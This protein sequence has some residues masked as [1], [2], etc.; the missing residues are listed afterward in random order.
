MP[1]LPAAFPVGEEGVKR[2]NFSRLLVSVNVPSRV[3]GNLTDH[4]STRPSYVVN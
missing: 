3:Q 4:Y 1:T 2:P